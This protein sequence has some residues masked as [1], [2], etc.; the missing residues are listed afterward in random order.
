MNFKMT[1]CAAAA[2]CLAPAAFAAPATPEGAQKLTEVMQSYL[3]ATPG[4]VTVVPQGEAY[5]LTM[6]IAPLLALAPPDLAGATMTPMVMMVTDAGNGTWVVTQ[7]Q[8]FTLAMTVP[9]AADIRVE[10]ARMSGTGVF[11]EALKAFATS[12]SEFTGMAVT[13]HLTQPGQPEMDVSITLASGV[14]DA[15]ATADPAGGVNSAST[16]TMTGMVET[17]AIPAMAEGMP[18]IN[19]EVSAE[20]YE[21]IGDASGLQMDGV[22]GLVKWVI[23]H[24]T[25]EA[26]EA[27]KAGLKAVVQAALPL[28][29][30]LQ[31]TGTLRNVAMTTPLGSVGIDEITTEIEAHGITPDGLFREAITLSGL[32]LP[33]GMVP[34]WAVPLL[35]ADFSIDVAFSGYD[36]ATPAL[37]LMP[38]FDL[39]TGTPPDP[40][41][42]DQA[43]AALLPEGAVKITLAPGAVTGAGYELTY[44][45]QMTAGPDA[46]PTGTATI[47]LTG[48]AAISEALAAAP[49]EVKSQALPSFAMAQGMAK[50]DENG[51]LVWQ[52]DATQPGT[53]KI[54]GM[55]LMGG[56]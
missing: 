24:P 22:L 41:L 25:P 43:L 39:P 16:L 38:L 19:I 2:L 28:F 23:A 56:Q 17:I 48:A 21:T 47:R 13:E 51:A 53:L 32:T 10:V 36:L 3:G 42:Q 50:P 30:T 46:M 44:Q 11:D 54:N 12:H 1:V 20:S 40:V 26:A 8:S 34:P 15:T 6:D 31:A 52:I 7:D 49:D 55:D 29:D 27:D 5:G 45:G 33:E 4:V 9:G 14:V 35:P 18:P 37:L